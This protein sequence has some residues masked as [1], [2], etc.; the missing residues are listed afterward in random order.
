MLDKLEDKKQRIKEEFED[1]EIEPLEGLET[2]L[3]NTR[4]SK[5]RSQ[6]AEERKEKRSK[7]GN[8]ASL[9]FVLKD[10]DIYEDVSVMRRV[11]KLYPGSPS[12]STTK[13]WQKEI[14][15]VELKN[16]LIFM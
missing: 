15:I 6:R 8:G 1:F 2:R 14:L 12:V 11:C 5:A 9:V 3:N 7:K 10:S 16:K 4:N 13:G